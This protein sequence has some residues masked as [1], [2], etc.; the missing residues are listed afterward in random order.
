MGPIIPLPLSVLAAHFAMIQAQLT[1][2]AGYLFYYN[3][4]LWSLETEIQLYLVYLVG[5]RYLSKIRWFWFLGILAMLDV[6]YSGFRICTAGSFEWEWASKTFFFG[7]LFEWYLG[8]FLAH[9]LIQGQG[10]VMRTFWEL[11]FLLTLVVVSFQVWNLT[12]GIMNMDMIFAAGFSLCLW[13]LLNNDALRKAS[14]SP[15]LRRTF[16]TLTYLGERSYS[17]Y[18]WQSPVIRS[19]VVCAIIYTPWLGAHYYTA[20]MVSAVAGLTA[21]AVSLLAYEI[22]ERH[23]VTNR[24]GPVASV[25]K[26]EQAKF[27]GFS[28]QTF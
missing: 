6:A 21:V 16:G 27:G 12:H 13:W 8:A 28:E 23:F 10:E 18:L 14:Y 15:W 11:A 19:V 2:T 3:A 22:V 26:T 4:N 1:K 24:T 25:V 20:L 7:H 5:S 9:R 17:L